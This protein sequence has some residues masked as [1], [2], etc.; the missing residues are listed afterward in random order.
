M[1]TNKLKSYLKN[2]RGSGTLLIM[3]GMVLA[4]IFFGLLF[5]DFSNVF[6]NKR[7]TQTGADAAAIAAAKTA[8]EY[9]KDELQ[10]KTQDELD[11]LGKEWEKFLEN[12]LEDLKE[13]EEESEEDGDEGEET[14][15]P[16]PPS[17]EELLELFVDMKENVMGKSMPGDVR[18][19]L[20]N[21]SVKVKAMTAMKFFF[22]DDEVNDMSCK[23][24]RKH[25]EDAREEAEEYAE[26]NQND[27]VAE[28]TFIPEDFRIYVE[29][30]RRG[31]YTTVPDGEVPAITSESSAK[32][33]D[34]EGYTIS[35]S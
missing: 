9:M 33:G 27:H 13:E 34:P 35:C 21:H 8:N 29:T 20:L 5:F 14:P 15:P 11:K 10:T 32:I 16:D 28:F 1:K 12:A 6:I 19:W 18:A 4:A 23:V 24:V 25:L 31:K 7:V 26:K 17:T 22:D 3:V 30:D 2:E